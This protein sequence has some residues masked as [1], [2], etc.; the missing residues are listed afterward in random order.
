MSILPTYKYVNWISEKFIFLLLKV[1]SFMAR[2]H[3]KENI[4]PPF[5]C[6]EATAPEDGDCS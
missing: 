5:V 4:L 6:I 3:P 1:K 2:S